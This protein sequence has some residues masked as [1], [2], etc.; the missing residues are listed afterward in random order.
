MSHTTTMTV[1]LPAGVKARLEKLAKSTDRST[2]YLAS[3]AI[4]EYLNVQESQVK[5]IQ[6]AICEAD[7]PSPV[8]HDHEEVQIKLKKLTAKRHGTA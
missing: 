3:R 5:A 6:H 2:A 1:R 8:F 4:E 7:S